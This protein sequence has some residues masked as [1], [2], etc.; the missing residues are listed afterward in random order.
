MTSVTKK[1]IKTIVRSPAFK[2][3]WKQV[4]FYMSKDD[5]FEGPITPEQLRTFQKVVN[6]L[7]DN[8]QLYLH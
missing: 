8:Y 5:V 7:K 4:S 2:C 3:L 6:K 1:D